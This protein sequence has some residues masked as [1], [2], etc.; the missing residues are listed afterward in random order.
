MGKQWVNRVGSR[1]VREMSNRR[2]GNKGRRTVNVNR[3]DCAVVSIVRAQPF[4]VIREPDVD[5]MVLRAC[6]EE[7]TLTVKL[8]L[9]E[10]PFVSCNCTDNA[11]VSRNSEAASLGGPWRRIG[12]YK[13]T[14]KRDS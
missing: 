4:S 10:R 2:W 11:S 6:K 7:I 5:N 12:L 14:H 1:G 3:P 8:D 13:Q 9:C